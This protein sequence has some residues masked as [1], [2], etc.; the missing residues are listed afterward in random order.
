MQDNSPDYDT[1]QIALDKLDTEITGG[2]V[3]GTLCGLLCANNSAEA[4]QWQDNLWPH[5]QQGDLLAAE[6]RQVFN[7]IHEATRQQLNDP[8]CDFQLLLPTDDEPLA[9]RVQALGDWCQ[10]YLTGL[11]L[12]GITDFAPLPAD[13]REL[14][15]DMVEIARADSSYEVADSEEDEQAYMELMEYLRVGVML[16]NEE[17]HPSRG[18]PETESTI[19]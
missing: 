3:H 7:E 9:L 19:H 8:T 12:G 14:I 5:S 17:L 11:A 16:I 15:E 6:A 18:A 1:L 4:R 10:G 2:E 13:A